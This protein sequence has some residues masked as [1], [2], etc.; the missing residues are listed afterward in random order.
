VIQKYFLQILLAI[1]LTVINT[2]FAQTLQPIP[3]YAHL[4]DQT[5]TLSASQ[6]ST[7]EQ[8]LIGYEAEKGTQIAVVIVHSSKPEA[9]EQF[10][11]RI[12]NN[13]KLGRAGVGDGV[14]LLLAMDD[15]ESRI[16]VAR[17]L[18]PA[19]TDIQ[20]HRILHEYVTPMF[21]KKNFAGGIEVALD[22][23][24]KALAFEKLPPASAKNNQAQA[25]PTTVMRM[26]GNVL[27]GCISFLVILVVAVS[28][29]GNRW[30]GI[31]VTII[32]SLIAGILTKSMA[33][34]YL[35][36]AW[37][38]MAAGIF[39]TLSM[40]CSAFF[41]GFKFTKYIEKS[42]TSKKSKSK[43]RSSSKSSSRNESTSSNSSSSGSSES[44]SGGGGD[45]AGGGASDKW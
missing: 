25:A 18:E 4:I 36:S 2:T 34:F 27:A 13:W 43:K 21:A 17:A 40:A 1:C 32:L 20:A 42:A 19:L 24:F 37:I 38:P 16:E 14:I 33:G 35:S 3:K 7:I 30:L 39:I 11:N 41:L 45:F 22:L 5:H 23:I 31:I 29:Y 12:G 6:F 15:H 8:K 28:M 10:A 44:T 9:I 26:L